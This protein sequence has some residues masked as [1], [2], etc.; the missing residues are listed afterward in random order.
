[1]HKNQ[2]PDAIL[3]LTGY[4]HAQYDTGIRQIQVHCLCFWSGLISSQT[5]VPVED[6]AGLN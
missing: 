3:N 1:M 6:L 2:I 5:D 4:T